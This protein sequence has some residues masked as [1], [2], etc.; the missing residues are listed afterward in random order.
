M[1]GQTDTIADR[2]H[3][4]GIKAVVSAV[5]P[6]TSVS[7]SR[8]TWQMDREAMEQLGLQNL[9]DAV[10]RIYVVSDVLKSIYDTLRSNGIQIPFPQRDIH[11]K[12]DSM[13]LP[14]AQDMLNQESRQ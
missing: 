3:D 2:V 4:I 8:P 12:S 1:S 11:I 13:E 9:A 7:S 10:K 5:K 14:G 6:P